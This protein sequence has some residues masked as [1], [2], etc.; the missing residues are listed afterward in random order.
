M[1]AMNA[2]PAPR[3]SGLSRTNTPTKRVFET[4]YGIM[5]RYRATHPGVRIVSIETS[6]G[7]GRGMVESLPFISFFD[8]NT[9]A[10]PVYWS[11]PVLTTTVYPRYG[12]ALWRQIREE[13]PLLVEHHN[14]RYRPFH[15][16]GYRLLVVAR[17]DYDH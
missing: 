6:D 11:L 12:E 4:F 17:S 8:D 2:Q 9:H 3:T 15:L 1:P 16:S 5:A 10:Q 14:G 7:W 13:R